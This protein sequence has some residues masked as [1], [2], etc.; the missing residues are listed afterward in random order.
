MSLLDPEFHVISGDL[1][2]L[3][4]EAVRSYGYTGLLEALGAPAPLI[5]LVKQKEA[6]RSYVYT[7][8]AFD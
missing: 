3:A 4:Q 1:E 6:L 5:R 8:L 7:G 2:F